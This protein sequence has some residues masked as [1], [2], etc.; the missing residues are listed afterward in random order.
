LKE[1]KRETR[2][3]NI[4]AFPAGGLGGIFCAMEKSP[5]TPSRS[6]GNGKKK[7]GGGSC[8]DR[9]GDARYGGRKGMQMP[10]PRNKKGGKAYERLAGTRGFAVKKKTRRPITDQVE[11]WERMHL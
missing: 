9:G 2:W 3:I 7:A 1:R 5:H 6:A 11:K 4:G 10:S 8:W